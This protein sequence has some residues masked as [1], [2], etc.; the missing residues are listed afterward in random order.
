MRP[1]QDSWPRGELHVAGNKHG[2]GGVF[3]G[4]SGVGGGV[5]VLLVVVT[6]TVVW[7]QL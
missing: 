1:P 3:G 6:T 4:V 2:V 7:C 5:A